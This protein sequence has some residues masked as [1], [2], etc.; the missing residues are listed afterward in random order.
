MYACSARLVSGATGPSRLASAPVRLRAGAPALLGY[1]RTVRRP[2]GLP[3][4]LAWPGR[5]VARGRLGARGRGRRPACP[6]CLSAV[7]GPRFPPR[8]V[9]VPRLPLP[10]ACRVYEKVKMF[11]PRYLDNYRNSYIYWAYF[12]SSGLQYF[13]ILIGF[14]HGSFMGGGCPVGRRPDRAQTSDGRNQKRK[15]KGTPASPHN[16]QTKPMCH[17]P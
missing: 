8:G 10:K 7:R 13:L 12:F 2:S 3:R 17:L 1:V 15:A 9:S 6:A 14:G 4:R 16:A 5:G 11:T